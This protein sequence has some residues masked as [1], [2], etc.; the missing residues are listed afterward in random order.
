[1]ALKLMYDDCIMKRLR[2]VCN[3]T[4]FVQYIKLTFSIWSLENYIYYK[5]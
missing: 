5:Q 3:K 2:N 4:V 1:M